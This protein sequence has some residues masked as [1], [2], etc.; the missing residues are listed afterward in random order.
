MTTTTEKG[1]C[2]HCGAKSVDYTFSFNTGLATFLG[3]LF[4]AGG[5]ARTN[6][7][8]LTYSQR[9]NS[10]KLRYW[11]LAVPYRNEEGHRKAGWW[12]ITNHGKRFLIGFIRI[13]SKVVVRRNAIVAFTG[14]N[15]LFSEVAAGYLCRHDYV[16]QARR[17]LTDQSIGQLSML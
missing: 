7:L 9:T 8:N 3:K 17:Q 6:D 12:R 16:E 11:A 1:I 13:P 14:Q 4:D 5:T 2:P 15:I 10:Q